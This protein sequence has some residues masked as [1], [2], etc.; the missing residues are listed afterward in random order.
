MA[1]FDWRSR[2]SIN[3]N[4]CHGRPCI[5]GTRIWVSLIMDFLAGGGTVEEILQEYPQ[6]SKEDVQACIA[7]GAEAARERFIHVTREH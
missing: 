5:K 2:V 1:E 6:L 7:Y 4:V 3:P